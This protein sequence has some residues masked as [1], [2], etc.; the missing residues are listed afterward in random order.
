[1]ARGLVRLFDGLQ[2]GDPQAIAVL[3]FAIVGTIAIVA[4]AEWIQRRRRKL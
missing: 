4:V 1:M 2:R 3:L